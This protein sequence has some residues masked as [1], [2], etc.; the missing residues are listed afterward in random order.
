M[1]DDC[2]CCA[3]PPTPAAT[4]NRPGLSAVVYRPGT[5]ATFR[6][7]IIEQLSHT[8]AL[9]ALTARGLDDYTITT[10]ELWSAVADVLAFYEERIANEAFL[11][12]ALYRDSVLRLV[13][14]IGYQLAPGVSAQTWLA[15]TIENGQTVTVPA[16]TRV[17]SVPVRT[18][19]PVIFETADAID[20]DATWNALSPFRLEPH[21]LK[22]GAT[23][24]DFAGVSLGVQAGDVLIFVGNNKLQTPTSEQWDAARVQSVKLDQK[25]Q[26]TTITWLPKLGA[27]AGRELPH[28]A[29]VYVL[30]QRAGVFGHNAPDWHMISD[31]GK[32]QFLG[33]DSPSDITDDDRK[34]WPQF[35][36]YA[37]KDPNAPRQRQ[38][39]GTL[40]I[41]P[42]VADVQT[43]AQ[44]ASA[45]E[46][47]AVL[48]DTATSA[49]NVVSG[50]GTLVSTASD[51][52][53]ALTNLLVTEAAA[54]AGAAAT[55]LA[56][57]QTSIGN[58]LT[59][60]TNLA[61]TAD[62]D[63][64]NILAAIASAADPTGLINT[65]VSDVTNGTSSLGS[66]VSNLPN[67]VLSQ[68][69]IALGDVLTTFQKIA[70]DGGFSSPNP[71]P[72]TVAGKLAVAVS[73]AGGVAN[74]LESTATMAFQ[75]I[76][77]VAAAQAVERT[78]AWAMD[79]QDLLAVA[80]PLLNPPQRIGL[81]AIA[82]AEFATFV[83]DPPGTVTSSTLSLIESTTDINVP[84]RGFAAAVGTDVTALGAAIAAAAATAIGALAIVGTAEL[85]ALS[86]GFVPLFASVLFTAPV[87]PLLFTAVAGALVI[88]QQ[89]QPGARRVANAVERAVLQA[90]LPKHPLAA[91]RYVDRTLLY[92]A[93]DLD[94]VYPRVVLKS[95]LLLSSP[96]REELFLVENV[97]Q[98]SRTDFSMTGSVTRVTLK[99]NGLSPQSGGDKK[100]NVRETAVFAVSEQLKLALDTKTTA[101]TGSSID[102]AGMPAAKDASRTL[103]IAG[104]DSATGQP[105]SQ[106]LTLVATVPQSSEAT[107]SAHT[108]VEFTPALTNSYALDGLVL[109]GNVSYAT[110]GE[111][112]ANEIVGDGDASQAFQKFTLKKSPVSF[113][114][115][116]AT[117]NV[118]SSLQVR[119][120]N[121]LWNEVPTLYGAKPADLVFISRI[122]DD[123]TMTIEFGDDV[124]GARLP[125]GRQNVVATYR[126]GIGRPGNVAAGGIRTPV[127]R[128]SGLRAATNPADAQA[129]VDPE[130]LA[131]ARTTA[132]GTVRT[133]GRA[134]AL[135]DF[136]DSTLTDGIVAKAQAA[137]VWTGERRVV[138]LTVGGVDGAVLTSTTIGLVR[139]KLDSERDT[140][141][142]LLI[143]SYQPVYVL[144][145]ATIT[146]DDRHETGPVLDAARS[147]LQQALSFDKLDFSQPIFLSDI[148]A[149][150]QGVTG[151]EFVRVDTLD[152]KSS[153]A[154]FRAAHGVDDS[155]GSLQRRLLML[156]AR[157]DPATRGA[158]LPAELA[159]VQADADLTL[160]VTGGI[161]S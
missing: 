82:A 152:L 22:A 89:A 93:I 83:L 43:A 63:N 112:I 57:I 77:A 86:A 73:A 16:H 11:R 134:V 143:A 1:S 92:D 47:Q 144:V 13:R 19:A 51:A 70:A 34:E 3:T 65:L 45:A 117:G 136:E 17:K 150:L 15:F 142:R 48:A 98:T 24:A 79:N 85:A 123:K 96:A 124:T 151:V 104:T 115:D 52:S 20:A 33:I 72:S 153:D 12:T 119:V 30:R 80:M 138:H 50:L 5:F 145:G 55:A 129:G 159:S 66:L 23:S 54:G 78:V 25:K 41:D 101:A 103:L 108:L 139:K 58:I 4:E 29:S 131:S 28:E 95:W 100:F 32:A 81:V 146:V 122:A 156:P 35:E 38:S 148:Y 44:D 113:P 49:S 126:Q 59:Q 68:M 60:A 141:Q 21:E 133:F 91:A 10:I 157:P 120:N 64:Q 160:S 125:T 27:T 14:L 74:A 88:G 76:G 135:R 56:S 132:P 2:G 155:L 97:Q 37:P 158:V 127:D 105:A 121:E 111:T 75:P 26:R 149:A 161:T 18:E 6:E 94:A 114:I 61:G 110:H 116:D 109:Y 99:G 140:N 71:G 62:Q 40:T 31:A 154:Q 106:Q 69:A 36:I 46:Q 118:E 130:S 53:N 128:P 9:T 84:D 90:L 8:P 67:Q 42:T 107:G 137:W 39:P 7:A 147:A 102:V 87:W